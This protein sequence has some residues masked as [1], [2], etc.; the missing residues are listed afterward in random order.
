MSQERYNN[1]SHLSLR[2]LIEAR[3][4]FH[5]HLM[6]KEN[7]VATAIGRYLVRTEDMDENGKY[8]PKH[9]HHERTLENSIV[10]DVSWPCIL[11]FVDQWKT[12]EY[13][14]KDSF[15]IIPKSIY[16]PDG[17]IV[18]ICVVKAD[19]VQITD[20][21][22]DMNKLAFPTNYIGGGFPVIV[23]NQG[24]DNIASI[25]C[26]VT[27]G[28]KYYALTNRHVT[29]ADKG[30]PIETKIGG[31]RIEVGE[32]SG[33]SLGKIK[34]SKLYSGWPKNNLE[35]SCDAGLVE[36]ANI[37]KW[38]TDIVDLPNIAKMY[39]LNT[40]NL[41]LGLIAEHEKKGDVINT[42]PNGNVCAY[43]AV[44]GRLEGEILAL[45]YRYKST[46]G[47]EYVSDFLIG[48]RCLSPLPVKYGDS[49][50]VW[51]L[52]EIVNEDGKEK[53]V[54]RPIALHWG[55]HQFVG[56]KK[57]FA[58]SLSTCLSN[59]CRELDVELVRGWN[60]DDDFSW[61]KV[62]HYTVGSMSIDAI[63]VGMANLK[64]LMEANIEN[65]S[66]K[67]EDVNKALTTKNNPRLQSDP[68]KGF[69]PLADVP[70]I[71]W[72]Q[73]RLSK[74]GTQGTRWGRKGD[75]N[76]NHYADADAPSTGGQTL[77]QLCDQP[78]KMTVEIW[79][80]YYANIDKARIGLP[81]DKEVSRGLI[82]FRVWQIYDY[83]VEAVSNNQAAKFIFAAGV[84]AHYVGDACQ[85]LH[86]SFMS[87]GNPIDGHNVD[88]TAKVT[89]FK[90]DGTVSHRKGEVYKKWINPGSG[91][92]S[93]YE[94][95]MIDDNIG[96]ILPAIGNILDDPAS[97]IRQERIVN[98]VS[99]QTAAFAVLQLMR[100]TQET[101]HPV[102]IVE[103][104]KKVKGKSKTE[105]SDALRDQFRDK[106]VDC[107]ARGCRYLAAVWTAAWT[108]GN[109]DNNIQTLSKVTEADLIALY[110]DPNELPSM[111][112]NTIGPLLK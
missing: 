46:G 94:D 107:M 96:D 57:Q 110:S 5:V 50:T 111:S 42:S 83:M 104:F 25:G 61:G 63:D 6:N 23:H 47:T 105:V 12:E 31:K 85:P 88:Y 35:V 109:G 74:N 30:Q 20:T 37:R 95:D 59:V 112:L 16:M 65:I 18:P 77:Y 70:D 19:K 54:Y 75:E 108:A 4:M 24:N 11:V 60:V 101:I 17:R 102:D 36:I 13:L 41:T 34:F 3:D 97:N 56:D 66:F 79:Q 33:K 51:L 69:C 72:K 40:M 58:F 90:R 32:S 99:G 52:E 21:E 84:L 76:P 53:K 1:F 103:A 92:H 64:T 49:G 39:D 106:T 68:D 22:V 7:V 29:G 71:I 89:S 27:D 62:G 14:L 44:S 2:D 43:G 82:C 55:Q 38:K 48:G 45:F 15:N 93:A 8:E 86:S 80:D 26:V 28:H 9:S 100:L 81:L 78:P 67:K 98:I 10:I 73:A 87:D 91:V